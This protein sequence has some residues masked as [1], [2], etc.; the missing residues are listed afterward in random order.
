MSTQYLAVLR[1][2]VGFVQGVVLYVLYQAS[3]AKAWPATDGMLFAAMLVTAIYVPT[4]FIAAVGNLRARTL[5]L[6]IVIVV[7]LC[8]GAGTYDIFRDPLDSVGATPTG[9]RIPPFAF[10]VAMTAMLFISHSLIAAGD[11]DRRAIASYPTYFD[12]SWKLGVQ[13]SLAALFTGLLW[14]L[15]Y[16]GS[17]LFKLITLDFLSRW[18]KHPWFSIPVTLVAFSYAVHV[19]DVRAGLVRGARTLKLTL[20]SWLLPV[21]TLFALVFLL[22]LPFIGLEP[23]WATR[24][25]TSILL[26]SAA[27]LVFLI[28]AAYQDGQS[29][30]NALVLR[31]SSLI[32]ALALAPLVALA[33]YALMLRVQQYGWT[34][35]RIFAF[36]CLIVAC[37]YAAG[38]AFAALR[39]V[40]ALRQLEITNVVTAWVIVAALLALFSPIADPA[41]IAAAD[42]LD[43]ILSGKTAP[44]KFDATFLR[45]G[46]GRYGVAALQRLVGDAA[47]PPRVIEQAKRFAQFTRQSEAYPYRGAAPA[48]PE[49]RAASITLIHPTITALPDEFVREDWI[50]H[51]QQW[52]LPDCL[53]TTG[54]CD[55]IL[56]DLDG[57]G[58]DEIILIAE[59]GR[60][61]SVA[62][63]KEAGRWAILGNVTGVTCSGVAHALKKGRFQLIAPAVKDIEADGV[64]LR[65]TVRTDTQCARV[66][67]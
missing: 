51:A 38:Y 8:A 63:R 64:R 67:R 54:K 19:T 60:G 20:E 13:F 23:L 55:A 33:G 61:T 44:E 15:L 66:V 6:W 12:I 42:Q 35:Q 57:D 4:I 40:S 47:A 52:M 10:W 11:T 53:K 31:C 16:L 43:R 50:A 41:R 65:L 2:A 28:N 56:A 17:E 24:K 37:C 1:V 9:R 21:M 18:L 7:V 14:G 29:G 62:F 25:A 30:S 32:A 58:A 45:F 26:W 36:A 48:T 59:T 27:V 5:A 49:S 3:E 34:P 46:S 39:S 22:A